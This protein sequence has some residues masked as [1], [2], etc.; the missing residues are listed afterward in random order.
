MVWLYS[1]SAP[2]TARDYADLAGVDMIPEG[3]DWEWDDNS[4]KERGLPTTV[5]AYQA[6]VHC[7][8]GVQSTL[9]WALK[10]PT[11]IPNSEWNQASYDSGDCAES[12][13]ANGKNRT[14][15]M[16]CRLS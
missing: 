15:R 5:G 8:D 9:V 10:H 6:E 14:L 13:D 16:M 11:L 4:T 12:S 3:I 1:Q 7:D 2:A